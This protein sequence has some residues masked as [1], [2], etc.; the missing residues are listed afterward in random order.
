VTLASC[1][2][3]DDF[4][5]RAWYSHTPTNMHITKKINVILRLTSSGWIL[6]VWRSSRRHQI[7]YRETQW[8]D[9]TYG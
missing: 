2:L 4:Y 8:A 1:E 3:F 7:R 9:L 5:T 6:G